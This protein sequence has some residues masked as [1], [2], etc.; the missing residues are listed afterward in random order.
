MSRTLHK[1]STYPT[2]SSHRIHIFDIFIVS[3][4][5]QEAWKRIE[6]TNSHVFL[7]IVLAGSDPIDAPADGASASDGIKCIANK[8][9]YNFDESKLISILKEKNNYLFEFERDRIL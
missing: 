1:R 9:E 8:F 7:T 3:I 4:I 2:A 5:G 6:T